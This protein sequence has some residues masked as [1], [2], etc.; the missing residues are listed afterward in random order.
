MDENF[1]D[2]NDIYVFCNENPSIKFGNFNKLIEKKIILFTTNTGFD[3]EKYGKYLELIDSRL[4]YI[5]QIFKKPIIHLKE[6]SEVLPLESVVRINNSSLIH[7]GSHAEDIEDVDENGIKPSKLLTDIYSDDYS[8]YENVVFC[9]LVDEIIAFLH[10]NIRIFQEILYV[11]VYLKEKSA[12]IYDFYETI[13]HYEFYIALGKLQSSYM[14]DIVRYIPITKKYLEVSEAIL[15]TLTTRLKKPVYARNKK[16]NR[17]VKLRKTNILGKDKN[18]S[19]IYDL[20]KKMSNEIEVNRQEEKHAEDFDIKYFYFVE[21]LLIFSITNFNF[22]TSDDKEIKFDDLN[23]DFSFKNWE[24][25]LSADINNKDEIIIECHKDVTYKISLKYILDE[26]EVKIKNPDCD[27]TIFITPNEN[28]A[29]KEHYLFISAKSIDSFRRFQQVIQ[30]IM[31]LSDRTFDICPFCGEELEKGK[32]NG[33]EVILCRSCRNVLHIDP[34]GEKPTYTSI[35]GFTPHV[36]NKKD[37]SLSNKW[38]YNRDVEGIYHFRN[39]IRCDDLG[40]FIFDD[41]KKD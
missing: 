7:L 29:Y 10:R 38:L 13:N 1:K 41:N 27:E 19:K 36:I 40:N 26:E 5:K 33:K 21:F 25:K 8:I 17:H 35:L 22:D 20:Y 32:E 18:Y 24:L 37:Y 12:M 14:R 6:S 11:H 39:I 3:F 23:I 30:K 15:R 9:N 4:P 2:Y 28:L 16:R 34:K 31:I